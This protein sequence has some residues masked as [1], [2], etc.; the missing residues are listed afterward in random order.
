[1]TLHQVR[2]TLHQLKLAHNNKMYT[3]RHPPPSSARDTLRL[4]P[5]LAV[6]H[7]YLRFMGNLMLNLWDCGEQEHFMESY[8]ER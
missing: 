6:E 3:N 7:S 2:M 5:T 8:F 1:M 4:G